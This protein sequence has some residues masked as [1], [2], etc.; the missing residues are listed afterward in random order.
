MKGE[1]A[2]RSLSFRKSG[3]SH[4]CEEAAPFCEHH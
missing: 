1:T 3:L 2:G 4:F